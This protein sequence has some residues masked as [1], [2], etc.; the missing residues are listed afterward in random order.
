MT[1]KKNG[2]TINDLYDIV[3]VGDARI[4][5]NE[6]RVAYV[7]RHI[8][9]EKDDYVSSIWIWGDDRQ[10]QYTS[11]PK[12]GS[13]RWSPDGRKLAFFSKRETEGNA[14]LFVMDSDGGEALPF[15]SPDWEVSGLVW[16]PD[17]T[18]IAFLRSVPT[19]EF[20]V[21]STDSADDVSEAKDPKK[22]KPA[23]TKITERLVFKADGIG[24]IQNRRRHIYVLDLESGN[25]TQITDGDF[26]DDAPAW[27]PDGRHIAFASNRHEVWD[28]EI[29][30]QI[31]EVPSA[32]G[33]LR[34]ITIDRGDW[35]YPAY[36]PDGDRIALAGH[37]ITDELEVTGFARLWSVKRDGSDLT[38]LTGESDLE[39]GNSVISDSYLETQEPFFWNADGIWFLGS[40]SRATNIYRCHEGITPVTDGL[41]NVFDFTVAGQ[42]IALTRSDLTHPGEIYLR[43]D[44]QKIRALTHVNDEYV[45]SVRMITPEP[46]TFKG[47]GGD[48]VHGWIMKPSARSPRPLIIYI[49]GGPQA[50]YGNSFFHEMQVL[51]AEGFGVLLINPHGSGSL[52]EEW[53]SSIHGEWGSR[54]FEDFMRAAD[55]TESLDWV[56]RDR[57]GV[58]GGSY[59]GY[60]TAWIIGHT[61]RF[62]AALAER[63]LVNMLSF[64]GTT[65]VPNWWAYA[66]RTTIDKDPM[67]LW[68]MS[69]IAYLA[70]MSTPTLVMHSENDH[71]CPIEQGEQLFT[72][73]RK[74][75]VPARF[76][77]FPEESHGLSRGGKPSRRIERLN[78]ITRWFERYLMPKK[79]S[80]SS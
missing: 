22:P 36:S 70:G 67:K 6:S 64:V 1:S 11:G 7:R 61:D 56:D 80:R 31:W 73:L 5:P 59:G 66:W 43:D 50:A 35:A 26:H 8:D 62:A 12:D 20:G 53:V 29:D 18:R 46:V 49:H 16:S 33:K 54:D 57:I 60:M 27:S 76:V 21:P 79:K 71:R 30:H 42:T 28:P 23:P 47:A 74:R 32:G 25:T 45:D 69:P 24:F 15:T 17:G 2:V 52:G 51:A 39:V 75:G 40:T 10:R 78:E 55:Y 58:G 4:H 65:D 13:P 41:H 14:R 68:S 3:L 37:A 38:D 63:S 19:D 9:R 77:R 34:Q 72:G 44:Q 48:D